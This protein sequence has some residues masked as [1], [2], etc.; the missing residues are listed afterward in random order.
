MRIAAIFVL[1]PALLAGCG[2]DTIAR[3]MAADV[4]R[5]AVAREMP[6]GPAEAATE[7][8]LQAASLPEIRAL[9]SD[10]GVEAGTQTVENIRNLAL[11]PSAQAC[12]AANGVPPVR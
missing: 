8:I 11:R 4:V 2:P 10:Y 7:C 3:K 5:P 9:A 6:A 12:F 1:G